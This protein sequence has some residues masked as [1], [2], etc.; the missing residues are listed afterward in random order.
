MSHRK[1]IKGKEIVLN[2]LYPSYFRKMVYVQE[3]P[4][5]RKPTHSKYHNKNNKHFDD[6]E[7]LKSFICSNCNLIQKHVLKKPKI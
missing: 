4:M 5:I 3:I 2:V 1:P 6:L 7:E